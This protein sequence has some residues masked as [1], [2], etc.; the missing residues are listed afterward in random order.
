MVISI[1][2]RHHCHFL[3]HSVFIPMH[4]EDF[5][6]IKINRKVKQLGA[7]NSSSPCHQRPESFVLVTGFGRL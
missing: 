3:L 7:H 6:A 1:T 4:E 5:L 2:T